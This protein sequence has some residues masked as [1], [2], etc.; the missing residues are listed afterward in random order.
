MHNSRH[1]RT[2]LVG[3][4]LII[5]PIALNAFRLADGNDWNSS[6]ES[7]RNAYLVGISNMISVG[8]AYDIKKLPG[9]NKTFMRQAYQGLSDTTIPEAIQRVDSWYRANPDRLDVPILSVLWIDI[10]KPKLADSH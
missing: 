7:E 1:L 9:E 8:N 10:V 3:A 2:L 5:M 4:V 6:T